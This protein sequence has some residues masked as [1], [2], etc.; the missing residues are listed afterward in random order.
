LVLN[1]SDNT[2]THLLNLDF[3]DQCNSHI[4]GIGN[5]QKFR[6]VYLNKLGGFADTLLIN[7]ASFSSASLISSPRFYFNKGLLKSNSNSNTL[8]SAD[9]YPIEL[10]PYSGI[11]A[12]N[13]DFS[14]NGNFIKQS[15]SLKS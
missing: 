8:I 15:N 4:S 11:V 1:F 3:I 9:N 13:G 10:F 7:S 12:E 2:L 5:W 6:E 14:L